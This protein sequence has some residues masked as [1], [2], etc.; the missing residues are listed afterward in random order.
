M[1][2]GCTWIQYDTMW[3]ISGLFNCSP[4]FYGASFLSCL[5]RIEK[6]Q[7]RPKCKLTGQHLLHDE[8]GLQN[9]CEAKTWKQWKFGDGF[10]FL[11]GTNIRW[12]IQKFSQK[13]TDMIQVNLYY[14][15][16][17][18][19]LCARNLKLNGSMAACPTGRKFIPARRIPEDWEEILD[20]VPPPPPPPVTGRFLAWIRFQIC[21]I[22]T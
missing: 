10:W 1:N 22:A 7:T 19:L 11:I 16:L 4:Q 8:D 2:K 12:A 5:S 3:C 15:R 14:L 18:L 6:A 20:L 17:S 9:L 13:E 21:S